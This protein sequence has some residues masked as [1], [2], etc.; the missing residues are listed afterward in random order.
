MKKVKSCLPYFGGKNYLAKKIISFFPSHNS[1]VEVFGGGGSVLIQKDPYVSKLEVYNDINSDV[2]NFFRLLRD[3]EKLKELIY[4]I[5]NTPFS[6]EEFYNFRDTW[7]DQ[8]NEIE[9]I[10]RWF[11]V[12]KLAFGGHWQRREKP[13]FGYGLLDRKRVRKLINVPNN[14]QKVA[15]RFRLVQIENLFW[16]KIIDIYDSENTLFYLDPPYVK[17]LRVSGGYDFDFNIMDSI[18]LIDRILNVKGKVIISGYKHR[19][20]DRL[21]K[22]NW[23]RIDFDVPLIS[24]GNTKKK[25]VIDSIWIS[26]NCQTKLSKILENN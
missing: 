14:I 15:N 24:S 16:E 20:H 3:K 26:P 8:K 11:I 23:R 2:V 12:A 25:R 10:Y 22:N 5:E 1:Y 9:K 4:K 21:E 18:K 19:V 13:A 7:K 6:R 17:S